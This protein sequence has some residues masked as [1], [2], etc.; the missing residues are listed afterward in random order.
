M[1]ILGSHRLK[2]ITRMRPQYPLSLDTSPD[3]FIL[4]CGCYCF[5]LL[6]LF[7]CNSG[8]LAQGLGPEWD[9]YLPPSPN[10]TSLV[11]FSESPV[12]YTNGSIGV[13]IGIV[14]L[15]SHSVPLNVGLQYNSTGVRTQEESSQVGLSWNIQS[16]GVITRTVMGAQA[17][18]TPSIGYLDIIN[19]VSDSI[20]YNHIR[21]EAL[22]SEYDLQP[23]IFHINVMGLTGKFVLDDDTGEP[24]LLSDRPW[25]I[26]HDSSFDQ[27]TL[28]DEG[29]T[30]YVFTEKEQT[31]SSAYEAI[32]TTAWYLTEVTNRYGVRAYELSYN[33]YGAIDLP[34]SFVGQRIQITGGTCT[35]SNQCVSG[36][37]GENILSHSSA[38]QVL[39]DEITSNNRSLKFHY[40]STRLDVVNGQRLERV[41]IRN[42]AEEILYSVDLYQSYFG[43][44]N[45]RMRLDSVVQYSS[46][47]RLPATKLS[48]NSSSLANKNSQSFDHWGYQTNNTSN[49]QFPPNE[50]DELA[51]MFTGPQC[52]GHPGRDPDERSLDGLLSRID[53]PTGWFE[54]F[55]YEPHLY[56]FI[57]DTLNRISNRYIE[58]IHTHRWGDDSGSFSDEPGG[59]ISSDIPTALDSGNP[60]YL[61]VPYSQHIGSFSPQIYN[62][63]IQSGSSPSSAKRAAT[64][65]YSIKIK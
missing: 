62:S 11:T 60:L 61:V 25:K 45:E 53:Y 55:E 57:A 18:E 33:R 59:F 9:Q 10:A 34:D 52:F 30:E 44:D 7:I 36:E 31:S 5:T 42:L 32:I 41:D 54:S 56:S 23:D 37:T 15:N 20:S 40:D 4:K 8:A 28:I 29:G 19:R 48:Y 16:G 27:W 47:E 13:G 22:M 21:V 26:T 64:N 65:K 51:Q 24:I 43:P 3:K 49:G 38:Q 17:D 1:T 63:K 2:P 50:Q 46:T 35:S 14:S 58:T 39:V 6:L 12:S